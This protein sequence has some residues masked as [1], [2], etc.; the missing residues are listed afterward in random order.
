MLRALEGPPR[1]ESFLLAVLHGEAWWRGAS[2][3][4]GARFKN[5]LCVGSL[6]VRECPYGPMIL[7]R[8]P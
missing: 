4:P 5:R 6:D 3:A 1:L 7:R 8:L 2:P